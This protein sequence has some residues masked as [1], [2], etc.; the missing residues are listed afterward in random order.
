MAPDEEIGPEAR[1][2]ARILDNV[3]VC[4][5]GQALVIAAAS[6][7]VTVHRNALTSRGTTSANGRPVGVAGVAEATTAP[8]L[9]Q[10]YIRAGT[11][12]V[13]VDL[14]LSSEMASTGSLSNAKYLYLASPRLPQTRGGV[15]F[16]DNQVLLDLGATRAGLL[17][18]AVLLISLDDVSAQDNQLTVRSD[19]TVLLTDLAVVAGS[20]RIVGNRLSETLLRCSLSGLGI[21]LL[22]TASLNQSTHCLYVGSLL[23]G[24]GEVQTDNL[25]LIDA[26][27]Q[28]TGNKPVCTRDF[29][30]RPDR[31][32]ST[33][34]TGRRV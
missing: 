29:G 15:M 4:E 13:I 22:V 34:V 18:S 23:G 8:G 9:A 32:D 7:A 28:A 11:A 12:V 1:P 21:G 16:D 14:G 3:V 6:G 27:A 19:N 26:W 30:F 33:I 31:S 25:A 20:L 2:A 24:A 10:P 5:D 17:V